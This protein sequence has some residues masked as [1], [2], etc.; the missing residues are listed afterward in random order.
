MRQT[1]ELFKTERQ[2]RFF[3]AA[4]SQS[5]L[6]TGAAY[7]ALLVLA[8]ERFRSPWA[9]SL[10]LIADL[11]P[12]MALGPIFG[13]AAD[14]WSRRRCMVAADVIR[15]VAFGGIAF[16]DGFA[17]TV[18]LAMLAGVGTG[19]FTPASLAGLPS[20]VAPRR[21]PAATSIYGAIADLGFTAGPAVA[22][23]VLAFGGPELV[24]LGNAATFVISAG[25]LGA[26]RFGAAPSRE[27][28]A[29]GRSLLREAR[30]GMRALAGMGSIRVVLLASAA[31]LFFGGLFNVAELLFVTQ[32]LHSDESGYSV[33]VALFGAGFIAGSLAGSGG[34]DPSRLKRNYLAGLLVMSLGFVAS[35]LA[36]V[37]ASAALTFAVA[38]FGNG[39]VLVYERLLIQ[40]T[41]PD[42]LLGRV[43]GAKDALTAWAF[44]IAFLAAGAMLT[45]LETRPLIVT[46]GAGGVLVWA[47]AAFALRRAWRLRPSAEPL[48]GG[49]H[50]VGNGAVR[51]DGAH[52][53]K[54]REEWLALLNDL[55]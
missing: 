45:V 41:V 5:A 37:F 8:Y 16:V 55:R 27:T 6:A 32:T 13:A 11:V 19:L 3:F 26:L 39:L 18:A 21:L 14:R 51:Q 17:P 42:P 52:L 46:A 33:L 35:G 49:G 50:P 23:L 30:E 7:V 12:A 10:V 29:V 36:P 25:V 43:F 31:V 47:G 15:A 38:G 34:G 20:L 24:M 4:L 48:R 1:L 28:S 40:T 53:V 54:G 44:A 22:A 9:I 2:A